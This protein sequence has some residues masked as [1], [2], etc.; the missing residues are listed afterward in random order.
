MRGGER[1][2]GIRSISGSPGPATGPLT[3]PHTGQL[4]E[5]AAKLFIS[6]AIRLFCC[7]LPYGRDGKGTKPNRDLTRIVLISYFTASNRDNDGDDASA[8]RPLTDPHKPGSARNKQTHKNY[9]AMPVQLYV[10]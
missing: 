6:S 9:V 8:G 5:R 7:L 1:R 4:L 10:A 3:Q 2:L